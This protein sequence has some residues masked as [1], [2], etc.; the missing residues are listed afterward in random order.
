MRLDDI[1]YR[2]FGT[3]SL[4]GLEGVRPEGL[5]RMQVEFGLSRDR[6]E[7]FA[8]WS[9]LYMLGAAPELEVAFPDDRDRDAARNFM[10]MMARAD[11]K[12]GA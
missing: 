10:D 9:I 1:L 5:E 8:L 4:E 11:E 7:R 6:E 12:P 2:Y 3:R